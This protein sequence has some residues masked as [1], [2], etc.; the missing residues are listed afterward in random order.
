MK[1][2][3]NHNGSPPSDKYLAALKFETMSSHAIVL[4]ND[5]A[6]LLV[7]VRRFNIY[8]LDISF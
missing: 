7:E 2:Q 6:R 8:F 4:C 3:E 5:R 1:P